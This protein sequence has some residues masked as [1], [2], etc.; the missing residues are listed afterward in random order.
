MSTNTSSYTICSEPN[1]YIFVY[2]LIETRIAPLNQIKYMYQRSFILT[3]TLTI[4]I[5]ALNTKY[6][7][8]YSLPANMVGFSAEGIVSF[9]ATPNPFLLTKI[10]LNQKHDCVNVYTL[11][12][13]PRDVGYDIH[14]QSWQSSQYTSRL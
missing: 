11:I 8:M 6:I 4:E 5:P 1:V 13:G 7:F 9:N 10:C 14:M 2:I 3:L 12:D